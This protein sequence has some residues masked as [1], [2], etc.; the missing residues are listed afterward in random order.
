MYNDY[1]GW[2]CY[3]R[4]NSNIGCFEMK[5]WGRQGYHFVMLNSNI[6]CFEIKEKDRTGIDPLR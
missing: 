1:T 2:S 6:G 5:K 3:L 4:L